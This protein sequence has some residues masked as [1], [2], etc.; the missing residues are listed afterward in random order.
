MPPWQRGGWMKYGEHGETREKAEDGE[1]ALR[2]EVLMSTAVG[3]AQGDA[4][5]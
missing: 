1:K 2:A 5:E 3:V 4:E